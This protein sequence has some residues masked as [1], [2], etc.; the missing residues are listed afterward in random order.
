MVGEVAGSRKYV[1]ESLYVETIEIKCNLVTAVPI[2]TWSQGTHC[3]VLR[4]HELAL[5]KNLKNM[6]T[7]A[8]YAMLQ[9]IIGAPQ[10][11]RYYELMTPTAAIKQPKEKQSAH[12]T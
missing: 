9:I 12:N 2:N 5:I 7:V 10:L 8:E 1:F 4:N 6:M 11:H 3:P